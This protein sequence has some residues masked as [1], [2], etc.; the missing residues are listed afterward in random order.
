IAAIAEALGAPL[1][2][3]RIPY[4]LA[5][6]IGAVAERLGHLARSGHPPPVMRY[7]MQL[8]GG[9]NRFSIACA[10]HELGFAPLVD[11][12]EGVRRSVEWYRAADALACAAKV[13]T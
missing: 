6:W 8:L 3:R 2:T 7:G 11:L 4:R 5:V 12:A 10:R 1:P 13:L 9:E